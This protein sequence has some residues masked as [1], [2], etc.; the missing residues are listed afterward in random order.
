VQRNNVTPQTYIVAI[1]ASTTRNLHA[2]PDQITLPASE[3]GAADVILTRAIL[4]IISGLA[5]A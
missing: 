2:Q 4:P 3:F 5:S 1:H